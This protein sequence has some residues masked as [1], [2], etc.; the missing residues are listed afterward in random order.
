M[1]R[2]AVLSVWDCSTGK[3]LSKPIVSTTW[4][5]GLQFS[6]DG[7]LLGAA[8]S[9]GHLQVWELPEGKPV[10][11]PLPHPDRVASCRFSPDGRWLASFG[12]DGWLRIFSCRS[13]LAAPESLGR[14]DLPEAP[15][16]LEKWD[17]GSD[18][19]LAFDGSGEHLL[20]RGRAGVSCWKLDGAPEAPRPGL[21]NLT[22][23]SDGNHFLDFFRSPLATDEEGRWVA[24]V[25]FDPQGERETADVR[26]YALPDGKQV[27]QW[28][29]P[30]VTIGVAF[31]GGHLWV[32]C[33]DPKTRGEELRVFD[34]ASGAPLGEPVALEAHTNGLYQISA[35][36]R[37]LA[38]SGFPDEWTPSSHPPEKPLY[39]GYPDLRAWPAV[40]LVE[41]E[42]ARRTMTLDVSHA[43]KLS[44]SPD[45]KLLAIGQIGG[46]GVVVETDW[47]KRRFSF[48]HAASIHSLTFA[49]DGKL[50][51]SGSQDGLVRLWDTDSGRPAALDLPGTIPI[52]G[53]S[54][55]PD[56]RYLALGRATGEVSLWRMP[57]PL[58][59]TPDEIFRL[60]QQWTGEKSNDSGHPELI[61]PSNWGKGEP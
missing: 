14:V 16:A 20:A 59:G 55:A 52:T 26:L 6:P 30:G 29:I 27:R 40:R 58:Q 37:F 18:R 11:A 45:G 42:G 38:V 10:S 21:R 35:D 34:P 5:E 4:L 44:F 1:N 3:S 43:V 47:G 28:Q 25:D 17:G 61:E 57:E 23:W 41:L 13:G 50:L 9:L 51:A 53:L 36:G 49:P 7:K 39:H 19:F 12:R 15:F 33:K 31:A 8:T 56:G 48:S 22:M 54:F 46:G 24:A 2:D 32:G 60:V